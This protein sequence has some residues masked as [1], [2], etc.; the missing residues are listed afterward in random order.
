LF[1]V[2]SDSLGTAPAAVSNIP[3]L[4]NGNLTELLIGYTGALTSAYAPSYVMFYT[5]NASGQQQVMNLVL[6]KAAGVTSPAPTAQAVGAPFPTTSFICNTQNMLSNI[7]QP[8]SV[9][10]LFQ[11]DT[12]STSCSSTD[13]YTYGELAYGASATTAPTPV[14]QGATITTDNLNNSA[15]IYTAGG[16]LAG[17]II[18]A[19][20]NLLFYPGANFS[21]TPTTLVSGISGASLFSVNAT[22]SLQMWRITATSGS[23]AI[24]RVTAAGAA[25][26]VYP[27]TSTDNLFSSQNAK[28]ANATYF[29]DAP[30][31]GSPYIVELPWSGTGSAT[32]T[33]SGS[34]TVGLLGSNG[35][36]LDYWENTQGPGVTGAVPGV[37]NSLPLTAF[38][39]ATVTPTPVYQLASTNVG[40]LNSFVNTDS[41]GSSYAYLDPLDETV[42]PYNYSSVLTSFSSNTGQVS[43]ASALF[44]VVID[45]VSLIGYTA[46]SEAMLELQ[47]ISDS[48][49]G[50]GG[51]SLVSVNSATNAAT[52]FT[53][54]SGQAYT[55]PAGYTAPYGNGFISLGSSGQDVGIGIVQLVPQGSSPS[56]VAFFNATT[57]QIV[58]YSSGQSNFFIWY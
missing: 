7:A 18:Q 14:L 51:A 13:T 35:T 49:N 58:N 40:L 24:Y 25:T 47:G 45:P 8:T 43:T 31:S 11:M 53:G 56:I 21:A 23:T 32:Y 41:S 57:H 54:L 9:V 36:N 16:T 37:L 29:V 5:N 3:T 2:P 48:S 22:N 10:I 12:T 52:A 4:A 39:N 15:Q 6:T 55:F 27:Y 33:P 1:V 30:A 17:F 26:S 50:W 42:N 19:G 20:S 46:P 28:D 38:S 34:G 44:P